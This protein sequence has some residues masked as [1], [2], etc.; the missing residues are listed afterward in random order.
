[1][2]SYTTVVQH[3]PY[4]MLIYDK[5]T[6]IDTTCCISRKINDILSG[7]KLTCWYGWSYG[8]D[9][10]W[11][12]VSGTPFAMLCTIQDVVCLGDTTGCTP[13][14]T[15]VLYVGLLYIVPLRFGYT[16]YAMYKWPRKQVV[17]I[18]FRQ[19]YMDLYI[20]KVYIWFTI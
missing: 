15:R 8:V 13:L 18:L 5:M 9:R 16:R 1:M 17:L 2:Y 14:M 3:I 6:Q 7:R 20:S 10:N 19:A 11:Q 4:H 12:I